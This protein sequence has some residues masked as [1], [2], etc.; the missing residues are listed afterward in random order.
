MF[1]WPKCLVIETVVTDEIA[2]E[3]TENEKEEDLGLSS[4]K[5]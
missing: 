2:E 5:F 4:G 1:L 3:G